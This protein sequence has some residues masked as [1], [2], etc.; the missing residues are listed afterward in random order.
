MVS[1][2]TTCSK[3]QVTQTWQASASLAVSFLVVAPLGNYS[4]SFK[5]V[6]LGTGSNP[7]PFEESGTFSFDFEVKTVPESSTVFGLG[8]VGLL[9]LSFSRLQKLTHSSLN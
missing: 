1:R 8:I 7:I 9:A 5:L 2:N 4:A 6:D 3:K